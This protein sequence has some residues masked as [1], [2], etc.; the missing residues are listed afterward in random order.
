MS[1]QLFIFNIVDSRPCENLLFL[2]CS[3]IFNQH[4]SPS[5]PQLQ[6]PELWFSFLW[7]ER[8]HFRLISVGQIGNFIPTIALN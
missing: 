8:G 3:V 6:S 4:K 7:F 1:K 5:Q 2:S